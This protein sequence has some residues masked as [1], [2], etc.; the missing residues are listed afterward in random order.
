VSRTVFLRFKSRETPWASLDL[1]ELSEFAQ[2]RPTHS[3][4][5]RSEASKE[6][7]GGAARPCDT[8]HREISKK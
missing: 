1:R 5:E 6:S 3:E 7:S 8:D 2:S 4:A